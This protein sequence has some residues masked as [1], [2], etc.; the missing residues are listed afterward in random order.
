[1]KKSEFL[2]LL[3]EIVEAPPGTLRGDEIL[4]DVEGWDSLALVSFIAVVNQHFGVT[5]SAEKLQKCKTLP[6]LIG[7]VSGHLEG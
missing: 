1:M 3:D 7:L 4:A 6:E 2:I 5:P